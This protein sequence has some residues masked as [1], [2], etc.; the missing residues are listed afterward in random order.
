M[1]FL[2]SQYSLA[3]SCLIWV[4]ASSRLPAFT[5]AKLK[6]ITGY[7]P[8]SFRYVSSCHIESPSNRSAR[9]AYLLEK[10]QS[11]ILIFNVLPKRR[12]R[13]INVTT[14]R[15]SHHSF[16]KFVLSTKKQSCSLRSEKPCIPILITFFICSPA[17]LSLYIYYIITIFLRGYKANQE[18]KYANNYMLLLKNS[19]LQNSCK[20]V[21]T[22]FPNLCNLSD[23]NVIVNHLSC[24]IFVVSADF[25]L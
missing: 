5:A 1:R 6:K 21:H 25:I 23:L 16:I 3:I 24:S 2:F 13:V 9:F 19:N 18:S 4:L 17:L 12:G 20:V 22:T 8:C 10:K 11:S 15:F 7:V 14:S